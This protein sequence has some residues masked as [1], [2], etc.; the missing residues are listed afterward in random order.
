[1]L[2]LGQMTSGIA[3]EEFDHY[4]SLSLEELMATD[5][6]VGSRGE[7]RHMAGSPVPLEVITADEIL[8]TGYG[9]LGKVLQRLLPSFNFPRAALADG[10]DH[11]RPFTLRGM[12]SDQVLVLI[13]GKRRHPGALLN[14]NATIGRGSTSVD[15]NMIPSHA[16]E[17]IE[18]MRDGAAAQYG[19]D[20]IAGILN[21]VLKE[22][23][24]ERIGLSWG[25][26]AEGDGE[27]ARLTF[28]GGSK[29]EEGGFINLHGEI[30]QRGWT[31]RSGLD[32]RDHY[33]EGDPRN[34][35]PP[36]VTHRLGDAALDD[37]LL[38]AN[39]E[40]GGEG[41]QYYA[42]GS[43]GY[44]QG[45]AT[46]FY[47]MARD[48]RNVRAIY[49]DGFL[50][51]IAPTIRDLGLTLGMRGE[52]SQGWSWDLSYSLGYSDFNFQVE[53]SLNASLGESSP[54]TFDSGSLKYDHHILGLD[55]FRSLDLGWR[56]PLAV[57]LGAEIRQEHFALEA[58]E[59]DAY[60][61]GG[62]PI[63][64]GPN[65]GQP[66]PV[67][68]QVFPGFR[69]DHATDA[70]RSNIGLY[71]DLEYP[72]SEQWLA[73]AAARYEHYSD[74]GDT[75]SSKLAGLYTPNEEWAF[76]ASIGSGF[77]APPLSQTHFTSTATNYVGH[78]TPVQIGTFGV[79]HPLARA[80]GA[81]DLKPEKSRHFSTGFS[82]Q[83]TPGW[84]FG[85]DYF[86]TQIRDRIV[87]SG[88]VYRNP[89]VYGEV[90]VAALEAH[91]AGG[92][93][94]FT[95]AI[96]TKTQGVDLSLQYETLLYGGKLNLDARWHLNSTDIEGAVRAPNELG[97]EGPDIILDRAERKQRIEEGQPQDTLILSGHYESGPWS[98]QLRLQRFG[99]YSLV[100]YLDDPGYDQRVSAKWI[101]DLDLRYRF[102][103][104]LE[105]SLGVHNLFDVYPDANLA[106]PDDDYIGPGKI[107][108]YA[109]NAPFGY[110]GAFYY[111]RASWTF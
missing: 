41:T 61:D 49:P 38:M 110:N 20:A 33:F 36:R 68:A 75:L 51:H 59:P 58:G 1:M 48:D 76:R 109:P 18:V 11:A 83:P 63:L 89:E 27:L 66:A 32:H 10:T 95:N 78:S 47:R 86:R 21:I 106:K 39:A 6:S 14:L 50:P 12:G 29:L 93:R 4:L 100:N 43:L 99:E 96:D 19:S 9:E 2:L 98:A 77:R 102:D 72:V 31:N 28:S 52:E 13:N 22:S 82:Y 67:G 46:G 23:T 5:I 24:E 37:W 108:P 55:L 88:D 45:D 44:R 79:E 57:A 60:R 35:A 70:H 87:L 73:Q 105:L 92:A 69:P 8:H 91:G 7:G 111:L 62:V 81:R 80:L 104:H 107:I 15:I 56:N 103:R 17:R 85:V 90:A 84:L 97:A 34:Q 54:R 101:T 53:G 26:T 3:A 65:A 25:Q 64:D 40:S 74:F 94:F 30:R 71:L 16:I 42:T